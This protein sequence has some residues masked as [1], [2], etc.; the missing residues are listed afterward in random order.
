MHVL[1]H[2]RILVLVRQPLCQARQNLIGNLGR[3]LLNLSETVSEFFSD[4]RC[5]GVHDS[6]KPP[7]GAEHKNRSGI[8][9]PYSVCRRERV[10]DLNITYLF[11]TQLAAGKHAPPLPRRGLKRPQDQTESPWARVIRVIERRSCVSVAGVV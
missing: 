10:P 2:D 8:E 3:Q 5:R 1:N 11:E 9:S 7:F 6:Q 4:K